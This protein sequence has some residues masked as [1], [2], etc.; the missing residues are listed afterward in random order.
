MMD[1]IFVQKYYVTESI[2]QSVSQSGPA[3]V[4]TY[5]VR[6]KYDVV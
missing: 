1:L 3:Y 4:Y 2:S 6:M 5:I